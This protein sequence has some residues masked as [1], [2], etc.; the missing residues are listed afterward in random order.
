MN[1]NQLSFFLIG[2]SRLI[3]SAAIIIT[4]MIISILCA[5]SGNLECTVNGTWNGTE[6][7]CTPVD[8]G[9]PPVAANAEYAAS[10][11]TYGSNAAYTCALGYEPV[12]DMFMVCASSGIWN[13]SV[14][15]GSCHL[16]QCSGSPHVEN[17][18]VS[19]K[20]TCLSGIIACA[21]CLTCNNT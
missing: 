19:G 8:C 7:T 21:F 14:S 2:V 10:S 15:N 20:W 18:H 5:G 6:P 13:G 4:I 17:G 11:T 3:V 9:T 16:V 12:T 1:I